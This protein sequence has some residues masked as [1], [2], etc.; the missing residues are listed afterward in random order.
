MPPIAHLEELLNNLHPIHHPGVVVF[1]SLPS[2]FEPGSASYLGLFREAEGVTVIAPE[3][4]AM[5]HG[6]NILFRAAWIMLNVHSDLHAVGLTAAVANALAR[7]GI[8]CNVVAAANHDHLFVPAEMGDAAMA[9][10]TR[11]QTE[12]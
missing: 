3:A 7:A 9:A 5:A 4:V 12:R 10:L 6:W 1:C 8:S 2:D 11:L